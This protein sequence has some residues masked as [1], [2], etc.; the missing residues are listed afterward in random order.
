VNRVV[1]FY[2]K[3]EELHTYARA[4]PRLSNWAELAQVIDEVVLETIN[5]ERPISEIV[6]EKQA[7]LNQ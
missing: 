2:H 5:S 3:M 4:L 6:A 1:P 7:R